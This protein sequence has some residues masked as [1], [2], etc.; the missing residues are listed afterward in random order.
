MKTNKPFSNE[1]L[2]RRHVWNVLGLPFDQVSLDG[3][4]QIAESAILE[5]RALFLSTPNLNFAIATQSDTDFFQSVVD[6]DLSVADGMPLI[7]VAK[8][9]GIPINERVAGSTL[10]DELSKRP[11]EKK[12]KVYFFGGQEG[13]AG[14]AHQQLN[15]TS[16]G[17]VSCGFYGPGFVS[18]DEMS[19]PEIID[20]INQANPDFVVVAL[21][22]QKGQQW[23]QKNREQLNAPVISHLGAVVNFVAGS[24]ERAPVMWQ[25]LG[26]EWLWR[27]KQEP[28]LWKRYLQDGL[29]FAGL[30]FMKVLP[31]AVYDRYLKR[32]ACYWV[33]NNIESSVSDNVVVLVGSLRNEHLSPIKEFF[34]SI[35]GQQVSEEA[36][37]AVIL[38][39]LN[40]TYIDAAFIATLM[41]FQ[42]LLEKKGGKLVLL[43]VSTRINR[44]LILNNVSQRF[45][46]EK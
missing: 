43:N 6:S 28:T 35:L 10:F 7:W 36:S 45:F 25:R 46:I 1:L 39:F 22:A 26:V 12:I 30:M 14:Q 41:L 19:T 27:I 17:M 40:V 3:G 31:L 5:K 42:Q 18:V 34:S 38:D 16:V 24:I 37:R 32:K 33:S 13:I 15:K 8:L 21:G 29:A 4:V 23:I 11:R 2:T 9:L 20:G 44:L